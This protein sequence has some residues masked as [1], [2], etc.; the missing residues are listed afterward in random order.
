MSVTPSQDQPPNADEVT[1]GNESPLL[2]RSDGQLVIIAVTPAIAQLARVART[3]GRAETR[4][5]G[6]VLR[7]VAKR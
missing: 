5:D 2:R 4:D 1:L 7:L 3:I 6:E